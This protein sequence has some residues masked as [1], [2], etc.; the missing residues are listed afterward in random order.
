MKDIITTPI[1]YG[2]S[3]FKGSWFINIL[4]LKFITEFILLTKG[5]QI[6]DRQFS[7]FNFLQWFI[8]QPIYVTAVSLGSILNINPMWQG[9]RT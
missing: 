1:I 5:A 2:I 3:I 9:R 8:I 6:F 4:I 7:I